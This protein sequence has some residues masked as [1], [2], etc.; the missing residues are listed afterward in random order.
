MTGPPAGLTS[1]PAGWPDAILAAVL[2]AADP[3]SLGGAAVRSGPG[4]LRDA[5][6]DLL[7][8]LMPPAAPWRQ[9]PLNITLNRLMGGLDLAATL[10]AG[11]SVA[12]R[13]LLA[14]CD[15]GVVIAAMAERMAP[16][17]AAQIGIV[18]D[19]GECAIERDGLALRSAT[20]FALV[21]LDEGLEPDEAP[22]EALLD[23]LGFRITLNGVSLGDMADA[24]EDSPDLAHLAGR[25]A[26]LTPAREIVAALCQTALALGIP[27]MRAVVLAMRVACLCAALR[28]HDSVDESDA[29]IAARLVL[30][31]RA[32]R[33]PAEETAE[34]PPEEQ[35][36]AD[37]PDTAQA[38]GEGRDI[39]DDIV[40][41]AA[42]AAL[43]P[44]L[45]ARLLNGQAVRSRGG[46]QGK[47]GQRQQGKNRGR[48]VG[49]RRGDPVGGNRLDLL[50][51]LRA[52]A[53]Y[54]ALR[55][56]MR[57]HG[58]SRIEVRRSDFRIK[59]FQQ[60]T[61]TVTIFAVDA[62]G[63]S[64]LHRLAE[65]KGAVE[66]LLADCY[67]R[68]DAVALVSFR[69]QNADLLLSPTRS[70]SRAKNSL[71]SLAGGGGTPLAAGISAAA[72]LAEAVRR[73]GQTPLLVL[74]TDGKANIA[75]DGKPLRDQ[76]EADALAAARSL[77]GRGLKALLIDTSPRPAP[78]GRRLAS[79]MAATYLP[80]PH[81]DA[82]RMSRAVQQEVQRP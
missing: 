22:P 41:E 3:A 8:G 7:R 23:R 25:A 78:A 76:A 35:Q 39:P 55:R 9:L 61:E 75:R 69:G 33:L 42:K 49:V 34:P 48:P 10:H 52:A 31:P 11:R 18:L 57:T 5:W 40:L 64:A 12:E 36:P 81:A 46:A 19:R 73:R 15:G 37:Q 2:L 74:L 56:Q 20:R 38:D 59:R 1:D 14:D 44:E 67:V 72:D 50:A 4:P 43:P 80:L 70:L 30:A 77:R 63:S 16:A 21:A 32:T 68:R 54:Q 27:S 58:A 60:R 79:E 24:L 45:L 6:L 17:V 26:S 29:A 66:L 28:G 62:S 13:G 82:V 53:P 47:A 51:T 71:A 65:A